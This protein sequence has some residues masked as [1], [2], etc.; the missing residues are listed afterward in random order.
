M[1]I[2][3]DKSHE[4]DLEGVKIEVINVFEWLLG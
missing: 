4:V 1:L 3:T 2:I